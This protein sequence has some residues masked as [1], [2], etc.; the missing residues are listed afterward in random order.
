MKRLLHIK[1]LLL[2]GLNI[3]FGYSALA[4]TITDPIPTEQHVCVG[5]AVKY[6]VFGFPG[7]TIKWHIA[8]NYLTGEDVLV[9]DNTSNVSYGG[10]DYNVGT[11][12]Y[13][14]DGVTY[15]AGDFYTLQIEEVSEA[16]A[17]C[18]TGLV[19]PG[20]KVNVHAKPTT[21]SVIPTNIVCAGDKG[22]IA[23]TVTTTTPAPLQL[24]YRL[25]TSADLEILGWGNDNSNHNFINLD[26]GDYKVQIRYVLNSDNS[27]VVKGS[28]TESSIVTII[29]DDSVAPTAV[30]QA[31]TIQLDASG[32]ASISASQID[33]GSSDNC[34]SVTL[35]A[36]KTTFD[37][38]NVGGN[39]VT[40]TV[41]DNNSQVSTCT[42]TVTVQDV[43]N[44][45]VPT[46]AAVTGECDATAV[47]PTTTDACAGTITGT[48]TDALTYNTQGTHTI[49]WT[50]DDGNGN[51]INVDQDVVINDITNPVVPTLAAVTGE[52]DATAVAPTTTDVCAGT[53]T[54]TT[55]D[56]LTYN[57]QGTHII[58]WTFDDGN[59]NSIN[60]DQDV[61][62]NDITN[63]VVPT[64]AAVTGEC[65]A[66]AVAPTTTDVCAG[67]ITGTTTDALTYNT[68]G[69]HIITWTFDDGNGNSINVDQDV[70][71]NDITN[72]VVP[73]LAAVTG[74]CDA[75]AVAPTT[76]DAC[77]GT[78]TGT[79]TDALT[80][81]TQGTHTITWTFDDG[82]GNLINVDQDVVINDITNPVVPTLAAVTGECDATAVA[83]T[84]TDVCA[85]TIT[86]TTTD[87]L[88]YNTQG[89]HII[90]WTFD[91]GNGN[92][93]NVDQDVVIND[94]TNPVV[95]TLAAVTGE[96]DATAVA[97]TTT[98]V[99][100]GTITGTTT[101]ALT[102]NTQGTHIITW[103]FDDG[104]GNS[105]NVDQDVV[106]NDNTNPVVPT[107]AAVTGECDA[108]AVAPTTTDACAG[109]ITG[110][111]TD[112]LT[113]NTQG[114]HTITWTF[115]D[116]NGNLINVD[117]DVV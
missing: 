54:G 16:P 100:A 88:T 30:C 40:L 68:Q 53:I 25:V 95:P 47:A 113:Y 89:T 14:W 86:G 77:A 59:G 27:K 110:T 80:Y 65:D 11:L 49:T 32:N 41:T 75:T 5:A 21:S 26:A 99:C 44:P 35:S 98:D 96:C 52:C 17:A 38:S 43:T 71:I 22:S 107:L 37:C 60:V 7:S 15:T 92:S 84:T 3:L 31:L 33:N 106:I 36:S 116:G 115:D 6:T 55:T 13:I 67:T 46:L 94:N 73:T 111:T 87:A 48:T 112:A 57:T 42:T 102:Y 70:V 91:D 85:G 34:G 8:T 103:T 82:N 74:E 28:V 24:Q 9:P 79:T 81:N 64:L 108:T 72:P 93:I 19:S 12:E 78:I 10:F 56:A 62:I 101:D 39:L 114:T 69:T 109:T 50:F 18:P 20:L 83:P 63:P 97:P 76:T 104:N 90:T 51:S 2:I 45:V 29:E 61:V 66:T 58:T 105:I 4:Q 117:Q 23:V 1:L